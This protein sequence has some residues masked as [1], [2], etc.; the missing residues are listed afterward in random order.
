MINISDQ[1]ACYDNIKRSYRMDD[2]TR[3]V[4][5]FATPAMWMNDPNGAIDA[6]GWYHIFYL[7]DPVAVD[8]L[9]EAVRKDGTTVPG[10]EKPNRVWAHVKTKNF[11]DWVYCPPALVPA[12]ERG[13]RKVI[14]GS[15]IRR[16]D[17]TYIL[18]YTSVDMETGVSSQWLAEGDG[19]LKRFIQIEE[20]PV[21]THDG[22]N[23]P[24]FDRDFR[25]PF[26]FYRNH[27]LY[28]LVAGIVEKDGIEHAV[29]ALY[30][31]V[32]EDGKKW[33]YRGEIISTPAS[34]TAYYECPKLITMGQKDVLIYSPLGKSPRYAIGVLDV[35]H[36]SFAIEHDE[37]LDCSSRAY[38]T[39]TLCSERDGR[40]WLFSWIPGWHPECAVSDNWRGCLSLA[41][42]LYLKPDG[43][44]GKRPSRELADR[45]RKHQS[46]LQLQP[47]YGSAFWVTIDAEAP[48]ELRVFEKN[49]R[50]LTVTWDG[51]CVSDGELRMI[52]TGGHLILI[53]DRTVWELFDTESCRSMTGMLSAPCMEARIM[54]GSAVSLWELEPGSLAW[55]DAQDTDM[56]IRPLRPEEQEEM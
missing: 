3:P 32:Q 34:K 37:A 1:Q 36:G 9:S 25:D 50:I 26:L 30:E 17:G 41:H 43:R 15:S 5:H 28:A 44:L 38:A 24:L 27:R 2:I 14:S 51:T 48:G 12:R 54:T 29:L 13:E 55:E 6:N 33:K 21:M 31:A 49:S 52:Y 11:L 20:N 22:E 35:E 53:I 46:G 45:R 39:V 47:G 18:L 56:D 19:E 8:G 10:V 16:E 4:C 7:Q 40:A 42:E 23:Q